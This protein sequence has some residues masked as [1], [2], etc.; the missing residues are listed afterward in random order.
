VAR[1]RFP[2]ITSEKPF[3]FLQDLYE[4]VDYGVLSPQTKIKVKVNPSGRVEPVRSLHVSANV[5]SRCRHFASG[6][7]SGVQAQSAVLHHAEDGLQPSES[8]VQNTERRVL[9]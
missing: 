3:F 2:A 9:V 1:K 5:V 8:S 4:D 7:P 6:R